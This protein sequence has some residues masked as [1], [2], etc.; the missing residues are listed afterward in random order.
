M[1]VSSDMVVGLSP[2]KLE[3]MSLTKGELQSSTSRYAFFGQRDAF[4][5]F[6]G[7]KVNDFK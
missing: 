7:E 1:S 3:M 5:A 2:S 4:A 6:D